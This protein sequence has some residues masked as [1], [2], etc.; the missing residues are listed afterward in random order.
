MTS[1]SFAYC[2]ITEEL[3][4]YTTMFHFNSIHTVHLW[5]SFAWSFMEKNFNIMFYILKQGVG[6]IAG[7]LKIK[8]IKS[9]NVSR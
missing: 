7:E 4:G 3:N 2:H 1:L 6:A 8:P 9:D 5:Y